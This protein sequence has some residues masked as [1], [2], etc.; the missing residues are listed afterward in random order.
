MLWL[1]EQGNKQ[2]EGISLPFDTPP[3]GSEKQKSQDKVKADHQQRFEKS[4]QAMTAKT[5]Q[6]KKERQQRQKHKEKEK[7]KDGVIC[8]QPGPYTLS[9]MYLPH[10]HSQPALQEQ[11][12]SHTIHVHNIYFLVSVLPCK[13]ISSSNARNM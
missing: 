3:Q 8:Q 9:A 4:K 2:I 13:M 11:S 5:E 7:E 6:N 1:Q 10:S 12:C